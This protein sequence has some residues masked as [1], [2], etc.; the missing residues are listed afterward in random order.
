MQHVN[1][2]LHT[3]LPY[4]EYETTTHHRKCFN[5]AIMWWVQDEDV[6]VTVGRHPRALSPFWEYILHRRD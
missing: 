5:A 4:R 6:G 1:F 2:V 3:I